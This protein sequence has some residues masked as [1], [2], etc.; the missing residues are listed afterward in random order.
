MIDLHCHS[1]YS[2]GVLTPL[3]LIAMAVGNGVT[4][5]SLTDHDTVDGVAEMKL[6][7]TQN[8]INV[9]SGVELSVSW[10]KYELHFLGLDF[11]Y[12]HPAIVSALKVQT[13]LRQLR[14]Q[15]MTEA[16]D[17]L[18][19]DDLYQKAHALTKGGNIT[20]PHIAKVLVDEGI[21]KTIADAFKYYLKRGKPGFVGTEWLTVKQAVTAIK[22]SGGI[23]VIAHPLQYQLTATKMNELLTL[24][25]ECGGQGMEVVSGL[26]PKNQIQQMNALCDKYNLYASTGSDFHAKSRFGS[27]LGRQ[28]Q[29]ATAKQGVWQLFNKPLNSSQVRL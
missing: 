5:L 9:V 16:L 14:A 19:V 17:Y 12:Q 2:D 27:E 8:D 7:G 10:K 13:E 1:T 18:K 26:M 25:K 21:V 6:L 29:L 11:D 15:K 23:A 20:R 22:Q 3:Q 28:P 24:F 4:T